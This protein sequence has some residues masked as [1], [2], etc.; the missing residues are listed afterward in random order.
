MCFRGPKMSCTLKAANANASGVGLPVN[1]NVISGWKS[2]ANRCRVINEIMRGNETAIVMLILDNHMKRIVVIGGDDANTRVWV[3]D[4]TG[5]IWRKSIE[6]PYNG[7]TVYS[8]TIIH[9]GD[10]Y[11]SILLQMSFLMCQCEQHL[12]DWWKVTEYSW[13]HYGP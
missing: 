1:D 9:K 10:R 12:Y 13:C 11:I 3:G 7:G 4:N 5:N 2:C 6:L 8:P